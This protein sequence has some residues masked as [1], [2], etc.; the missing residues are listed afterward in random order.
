[1][2][3]GSSEPHEGAGA[4]GEDVAREHSAPVAAGEGE[5]AR[6]VGGRIEEDHSCLICGYN[7]K[8]QP[9]AGRCPECGHGVGETLGHS[10]PWVLQRPGRRAEVG[11]LLL[12]I[13]P[14]GFFCL[15]MV[16]FAGATS[17]FVFDRPDWFPVAA[18][19]FACLAVFALWLVGHAVMLAAA[20][21]IPPERSGRATVAYAC[22]LIL[23]AWEILLIATMRIPSQV[24]MEYVTLSMPAV[25]ALA[26]LILVAELRRLIRQVR[27]RSVADLTGTARMFIV[28]SLIGYGLV[29]LLTMVESATGFYVVAGTRDLCFGLALLAAVPTAGVIAVAAWEFRLR[30]RRI[31]Q[32]ALY[33]EF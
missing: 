7:L 20:A 22:L 15:I 4:R 31:R 2:A 28:A 14:M 26:Q 16:G 6:A 25:L 18:Y 29:L 21:R 3:G 10:C 13:G 12:C 19:M 23:F 32:L 27:S 11:A 8:H 1:M 9:V 33:W 30:L 17:T 5:R 24:W